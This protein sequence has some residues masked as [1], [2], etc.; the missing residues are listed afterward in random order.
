MGAP[1]RQQLVSSLLTPA[2]LNLTT[3]ILAPVEPPMLIPGSNIITA[4]L[5]ERAPALPPRVHRL[6]P[7]L[8]FGLGHPDFPTSVISVLLMALFIHHSLCFF[9]VIRPRIP[10]FDPAV[11]RPGAVVLNLLRLVE[12]LSDPIG[13]WNPTVEHSIRPWNPAVERS[14]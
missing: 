9:S 7:Q 1:C 10:L 5:M 12:P 3:K 11:G 2:A 4:S 13:A 8:S 6:S 14:D